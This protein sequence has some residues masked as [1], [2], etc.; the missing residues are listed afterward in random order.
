MVMVSWGAMLHHDLLVS[1]S[2][3]GERGLSISMHTAL[4][5]F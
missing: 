1:P 2:G 4:E 5:N 3:R